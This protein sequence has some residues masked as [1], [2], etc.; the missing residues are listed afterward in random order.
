MP[1]HDSTT[2][3]PRGGNFETTRW[4]MVLTAADGGAD[5]HRR[6]LES[7]CATYWYPLYAF[8]RRQ[9][10]SAHEAE[11]LTQGFFAELLG[12]ERLLSVDRAKGKFRSFL[13]ASMKHFLAN[14]WDRSQTLKRGGGIGFL[15]MEEAA[16]RLYREEPSEQLS[17]EQLYDRRWALILVERV[18]ERLRAENDAAGKSQQF[19]ELQFCLTGQPGDSYAEIGARLGKSEG[20][21]KVMIHRLRDR[22]RELLR[23]EIAD[24]VGGDGDVDEELRYLLSALCV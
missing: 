9:G 15:S 10:R 11:D 5:A 13:L 23:A 22:Y 16:E 19:A 12:K 18:M 21:V 14:D 3:R 24:T 4:S 20:A 8:V 17:A 2:E 7:L 1:L 6:A